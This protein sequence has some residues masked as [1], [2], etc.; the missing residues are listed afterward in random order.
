MLGIAPTGESADGQE[1]P[2]RLPAGRGQAPV[3][4][5]NRPRVHRGGAD[6]RRLVA[7]L[8]HGALGRARRGWHAGAGQPDGAQALEAA[9][10]RLVPVRPSAASGGQPARDVRHVRSRLRARPPHHAPPPRP[11][12]VAARQAARRDLLGRPHGERAAGLDDEPILK[13]RTLATAP[14]GATR[15]SVHGR[16]APMLTLTRELFAYMG[17][18]KKWWLLPILIVVV[19]FGGLLLLAQGSAVAPFIYTIF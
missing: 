18:R 9:E 13:D 10:P 8:T 12:A 16:E 1:F 4:A 19:L 17:A 11:P 3:R 7:Q 2:R 5:R 14:V 6:R 15:Q